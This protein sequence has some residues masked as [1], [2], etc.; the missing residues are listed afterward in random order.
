MTQIKRSLP[1]YKQ[2]SF[3]YYT[4]TPRTLTL[5]LAYCH[6]NQPPQLPRGRFLAPSHLRALAGWIDQ[7]KPNLLTVR[8]HPI[9]ASHF[10][11]LFAA[12]LLAFTSRH[13]VLSPQATDWLKLPHQA[14]IDRL[15]QTIQQP[16]IWRKT[17]SSLGWSD[18]LTLDK[19][20]YLEQ[21]LARQRYT[22]PATAVT[23]AR[24][25]ISAPDAWKLTL[26]DG[27]PTWLL[28]DLL[29]LG[30][31]LPDGGLRLAPLSIASHP[32]YHYGYDHIRWLLE[33]AIQ[34]PLP[35]AQR[36]Q[37][38]SWLRRAHAYRIHGPLLSTAHPQQLQNIWQNRRLRP[39][40]LE[41]ISPR[42]ALIDPPLIPK[43]RRWLARQG[44]PL[45][46]PPTL[47]EPSHPNPTNLGDLDLPTHWFSLRLLLGLQ[48]YLRLP[49]PAPTAQLYSLE[50][51][52]PPDT[53][54]E[55]ERQAQHTLQQLDDVIRGRDAFFPAYQS[56][57][58]QLFNAIKE[59]IIA[60]S[61]L[62]IAYRAA[63]LCEVRW[64]EI[65]PLR[66]ETRAA[67]TY[68][69]AYSYRAQANRTFRLDR[70]T[71]IKKG[72]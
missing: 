10:T 31:R 22:P 21:M 54:A 5:C 66:L 25:A 12:D 18:I 44:Y 64:H 1:V 36:R 45:N 9:L 60:N 62:H 63:G 52:L 3:P 58:P 61:T 42:H 11:L 49:H 19:V 13:L 46:Q 69:H 65:E 35:A 68:L 17:V 70:I 38:R 27:L 59:A 51:T 30:Q 67:L 71:A 16:E 6:Q 8:R 20:A 15:Y 26:P 53:V 29:Q 47:S 39:Y 40:I 50:Q 4:L 32:A 72:K 14:Q 57:A 7:P 41:Q 33:T 24:L 37:L 55:L 2:D 23:A 43:L 56:P 34:T 48:K 28:F